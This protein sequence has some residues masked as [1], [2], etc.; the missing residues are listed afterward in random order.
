MKTGMAIL[1]AVLL[2]LTVGCQSPPQAGTYSGF[3]GKLGKTT[4]RVKSDGTISERYGP[5]TRFGT[6]TSVS[7]TIVKAEVHVGVE[8]H[9]STRYYLLRKLDKT[10][11]WA[12]SLEDLKE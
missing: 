1:T 4:L 10:Y 8:K 2:A 9:P 12:Y 6:W 11:Q 5:L 7:E 3:E